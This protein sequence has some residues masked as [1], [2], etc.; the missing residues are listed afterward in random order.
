MLTLQQAAITAADILN[1]ILGNIQT[2][3]GETEHL[4]QY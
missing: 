1:I 3:S 4:L 2:L